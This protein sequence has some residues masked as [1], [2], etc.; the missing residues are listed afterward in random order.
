MKLLNFKQKKNENKNSGSEYL[1]LCKTHPEN[2][3]NTKKLLEYLR[4]HQKN[5]IITY[6]GKVPKLLNYLLKHISHICC[7]N[8]D[9]RGTIWLINDRLYILCNTRLCDYEK[10]DEEL[11]VFQHLKDNEICNIDFVINDEND[12]I[13]CLY[14]G[15]F[16]IE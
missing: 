9:F 5:E 7:S 15:D 1:T 12:R 3:E 6:I 14:E 8:Y 16:I 4:S 13:Y 2:K 10:D 11:L